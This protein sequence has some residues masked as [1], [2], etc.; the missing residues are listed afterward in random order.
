MKRAALWAC[1]LCVCGL[2]VWGL[3]PARASDARLDKV[4]ADWQQRQDRVKV[5]EYQVEGER[6]IP[7]GAY[8]DLQS[9][10]KGPK[11]PKRVTPPED[12]I[13]PVR[14]T[15]L[16]D[17]A[18]ER[19]RLDTSEFAF[20]LDTGHSIRHVKAVAYNGSVW[21][22]L[23]PKDKNPIMGDGAPEMAVLSGNMK[24][25]RF[26]V[27]YYPIFFGHGRVCGVM[28]QIVPGSLKRKPDP[29]S[30]HVHGTAVLD[31]RPCL[32]LRTQTLKMGGT[33]FCEY[34]VDTA[35]ESAIV[36]FVMYGGDVPAGDMVIQ[37]SKSA[38]GWLPD[39]WR[40]TN[41]EHGKTMSEDR[42]HV[43]K[44]R[45]DPVLAD[46]HFELEVKPGMIVED[47]KSHPTKHPL[48]SP[49]TD[50]SVYQVEA[51]GGRK[52]MPD[53]YHREADQY[54]QHVRH[55]Y[56]LLLAPVLA[57]V[58]GMLFWLRRRRLKMRNKTS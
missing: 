11:A 21:K 57:A 42:M 9:V 29:G 55:R 41:L 37:Y 45:I 47:L 3:A 51:D 46:S 14:F 53:P 52:Y 50:V 5:I 43:T 16:L 7:K 20:D 13:G 26:D 6:K 28:D 44:V 31:D 4:L 33:G 23:S 40:W 34:W 36:R 2:L 12:M 27:R 48:E 10:F 30:L 17:F 54:R 56:W 18:R 19:F 32:V 8:T 1:V 24:N 39:R 38:E 25:A 15:L 22:S 35:R 49:A 58:L